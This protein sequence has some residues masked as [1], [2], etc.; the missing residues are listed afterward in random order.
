MFVERLLPA[1]ILRK[2]TP[3]EMEVYRKPFAERG[4]ARRP[5]LTWPREIPIE[6]EGRLCHCD[7]RL[8]YDTVNQPKLEAV[9]K[10]SSCGM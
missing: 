10:L 5:T 7:V 9:V 4:E 1:S 2:L 3:E 6:S 8:F